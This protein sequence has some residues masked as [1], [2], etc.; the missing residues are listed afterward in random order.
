[1][2]TTLWRNSDYLLYWWSRAS[3]ILGSQIS[4]LAIPL[5]AVTTLHSAAEASLVTVCGYGSGLLFALHA[6]V[7][8]D[9]F[10]R[11]LVMVAADVVRAALLGLLAWQAAV[12]GA[13]LLSMC[14]IALAV[15]ALSVVFDSAAAAVLPDLVGEGLFARAMARNQSRDFALA[16]VGPLLGAA[17]MKAGPAWAFT[18][19]AASYVVSALL[20]AFLSVAARGTRPVGLSL[21]AIRLGIRL[22]VRDWLLV[23]V[24]LYLGVL[25]LVLTAAVFA[26]TVQFQQ[27][28]FTVGLALA[29]QAA[30]GMIGSLVADRLHGRF[31]ATVLA[32]SHG[33][34]W[35]LG[36]VAI[37]LVTTTPVIAVS[38]GLGWLLGPA[39]RVAFGAR[40]VAAVGPEARARAS[41]A[42]S[43]VT[44][45][46]SLL[47][48]MVGGLLV[49]PLGYG[50]AVVA[51]GLVA[52]AA[53][54]IVHSGR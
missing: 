44:S 7:V 13:S 14:L 38:F 53:V 54:T 33:T 34:L 52:L 36:L 1:L 24:T 8:G 18:V 25:N 32:S 47:G 19:D 31:S 21:T 42:T 40:L 20:L 10:D 4:Y 27:Q 50:G 46:F 37:G 49:G 43:L 9:R 16:L 48:P 17:L 29:A 11:K 28:S 3:S 30:G 45:S 23:R 26:T 22:V 41:S 2:A 6:G 51:L 35:F 12:G 5:F 39:L 15:G